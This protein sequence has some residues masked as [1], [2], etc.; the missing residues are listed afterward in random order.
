MLYEVINTIRY[1]E[2]KGVLH[3]D[4]MEA[5]T[6]ADIKQVLDLVRDAYSVIDKGDLINHCRSIEGQFEH[7]LRAHARSILRFAYQA[8][9]TCLP[10]VLVFPEESEYLIWSFGTKGAIKIERMPKDTR[11]GKVITSG[12][13]NVRLTGKIIETQ[14]ESLVGLAEGPKRA[15]EVY[16]AISTYNTVDVRTHLKGLIHD[17]KRIEVINNGNEKALL[18]KLQK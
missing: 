1:F 17:D 16:F 3:H 14:E 2:N 12:L 13:W 10:D 18:S 4:M 8:L 5:Y 7:A 11:V 9:G 6:F 15:M